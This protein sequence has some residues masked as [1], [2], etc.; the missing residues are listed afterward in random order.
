MYLHASVEARKRRAEPARISTLRICCLPSECRPR[1]C[2]RHQKRL[3]QFHPGLNA[4]AKSLVSGFSIHVNAIDSGHSGPPSGVIGSN[5]LSSPLEWQLQ[6]VKHPPQKYKWLTVSAL[7]E[8]QT[9]SHHLLTLGMKHTAKETSCWRGE[10][11]PLADNRLAI[12]EFDPVPLCRELVVG[13]SRP[14]HWSILSEKVGCRRILCAL[15]SISP[16]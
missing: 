11:I 6:Y 15:D 12:V 2:L 10:Q 3:W 4:V 7:L 5:N 14:N 13:D 8:N 9:R 1:A 16:K